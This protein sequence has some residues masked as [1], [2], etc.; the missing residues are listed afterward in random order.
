MW[1]SHA[2]FRPVPRSSWRQFLVIS[3]QTAV[4]I[5]AIFAIAVFPLLIGIAVAD[6]GPATVVLVDLGSHRTDDRELAQTLDRYRTSG[7]ALVVIAA[8]D[9][10]D[11]SALPGQPV[12]A[13]IARFRDAVTVQ[14]EPA[15]TDMAVIVRALYGPG[16]SPVERGGVAVADRGS[17]GGFA[18]G[19]AL[20]A[21][22]ALAAAGCFV[23]LFPARSGGRSADRSPWAEAAVGQ[24]PPVPWAPGAAAVRPGT[25]AVARTRFTEHGGYVEIIDLV[26]WA[27]LD[28]AGADQVCPGQPLVVV[29]RGADESP[30]VAPW[31]QTGPQPHAGA[32]GRPR[33][34]VAHVDRCD[35]RPDRDHAGREADDH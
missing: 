27:V 15:G 7:V 16:P 18:A 13:A 31:Q 33:T 28:R 26:V 35:D 4:D 29:G 25:S 9:G 2:M 23:L 3:P 14:A 22:L 11:C 17:G 34:T 6:R 32:A 8:P 21:A 5:V 10:P 20:L 19:V 12:C 1:H 24:A 30:V